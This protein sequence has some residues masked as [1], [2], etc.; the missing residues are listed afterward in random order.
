MGNEDASEVYSE[1][2]GNGPAE[3]VWDYR[4]PKSIIDK[5][6]RSTEW[7]GSSLL[8]PSSLMSPV[9]TRAY[10]RERFQ[11]HTLWLL[12]HHPFA[13]FPIH[14]FKTGTHTRFELDLPDEEYSRSVDGSVIDSL[15][16]KM[17]SSG[18]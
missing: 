12:G 8:L 18:L 11:P 1:A 10:V 9:R 17:A 16:S 4:E 3:A 14:F 7:S 15:T 5:E 2:A 6:G 13:W